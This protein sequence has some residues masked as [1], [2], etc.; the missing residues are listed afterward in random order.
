MGKL[1]SLS[2]EPYRVNWG[3][4]IHTTEI[5]HWLV[6]TLYFWGYGSGNLIGGQCYGVEMSVCIA[7]RAF[8]L[9][10][11]FLTSLDSYSEDNSVSVRSIH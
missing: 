7:V 8:R 1:V 11:T 2:D 4:I 5:Y 9:C 10:H 3:K 6:H